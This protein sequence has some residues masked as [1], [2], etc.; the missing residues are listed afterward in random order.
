[1]SHPSG[2]QC[3]SLLTFFRPLWEGQFEA[4]SMWLLPQ[5][6][7]TDWPSPGLRVPGSSQSILPSYTMSAVF[8]EIP[9]LWACLGYCSM[10]IPQLPVLLPSKQVLCEK[11]CRTD[12]WI[13]GPIPKDVCTELEDS[14]RFL[15]RALPNVTLLRSL[16]WREGSHTYSPTVRTDLKP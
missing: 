11:I 9:P 10:P 6:E 15:W 4:G 8:P 14:Q 2:P 16:W 5:E 3:L 12:G 1:M 13:D 7:R